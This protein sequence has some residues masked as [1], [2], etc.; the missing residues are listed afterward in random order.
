MM[1]AEKVTQE[2]IEV[3]AE[4][5][6]NQWWHWAKSLTPELND[7]LY[8]LPEGSLE[9]DRLAARLG[10][11]SSLFMPYDQLTEEQ[12][13]QDRIWARESLSALKNRGDI[14]ILD[15]E[16]LPVNR[17]PFMTVNLGTPLIDRKQ[18]TRYCDYKVAQEDMLQW[19]KDSLKDFTV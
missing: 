15:E 14:K 16:E 19:H 2:I 9:A 1:E 11:W 18:R 12:K 7:I 17:F 8:K 6:H 3:L 13:E 10:R 5:E 4:L